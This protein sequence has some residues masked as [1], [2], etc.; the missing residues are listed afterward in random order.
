MAALALLRCRSHRFDWCRRATAGCATGRRAASARDVAPRRPIASCRR[1]VRRRTAKAARFRRRG[2]RATGRAAGAAAAPARAPRGAHQ[3]AADALSAPCD[4]P[5]ASSPLGDSRRV[6]RRHEVPRGRRSRRPRAQRAR[7]AILGA[8]RDEVAPPAAIRRF[9]PAVRRSGAAAASPARRA[10]LQPAPRPRRRAP[11]RCRAA[12]TAASPTSRWSAWSTA[13]GRRRRRQ[14]LPVV[15]AAPGARAGRRTGSARGGAGG[16]RRSAAPAARVRSSSRPSRSTMRR[17]CA[18]R[19]CRGARRRCAVDRASTGLRGA[20]R[21]GGRAAGALRRESRRPRRR[22]CAGRAQRRR[23]RR[24]SGPVPPR[25]RRHRVDR[26]A[27]CPFKYFAAT[28]WPRGR[29]ARTG[30]DGAGAR[31]VRPRSV[32]TFFAVERARRRRSL[33]RLPRRARCSPSVVDAP[34]QRLP[35]SERAL[36]RA[37]LLGSI[38]GAGLGER[39]FRFEAA[40]PHVVVERLLEVAL[41]G[42]SRSVPG[43]GRSTARHGRPHRPARRRHAAAP[44]LQDRQGA[45][46]ARAAAD[47]GLRALRRTRLHGHRGRTWPVAEAGYL[48]FGRAETRRVGRLGREARRRL[49]RRASAFANVTRI[50]SGAFPVAPTTRTCQFCG[51]AAVCRKDYVGD[52]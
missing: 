31:H 3:R 37:A 32:P 4:A 5:S 15:G 19:R 20:L 13:S 43:A 24:R 22:R 18:R 40:R 11:R 49:A 6:P 44:R 45:G 1:V 39:V 46:R 50:E 33:R 12:R 36:E 41:D 25:L 30:A 35:P 10:D 42:D 26:Y 9:A 28:C 52:E 21:A 29:A 17:S 23:C 8:A 27:R 7:G 47:A 34:S 48:A 2:R 16:V 14:P 51:F 38:A